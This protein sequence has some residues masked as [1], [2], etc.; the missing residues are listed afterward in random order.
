MTH[1]IGRL[2]SLHIVASLLAVCTI[3][4]CGED[5]PAAPANSPP[6]SPA[7]S[8]TANPAPAAAA[9]SES[10]FAGKWKGAKVQDGSGKNLTGG[11]FSD[12]LAIKLEIRPD[13]T[14]GESNPA[15]GHI[16]GTWA[17]SGDSITLTNKTAPTAKPIKLT[18]E[19]PNLVDRANPDMVLTY[20]KTGPVS[21]DT[22]PK[23]K[24]TAADLQ[25]EL[26]KSYDAAKN[27]YDELRIELTGIVTKIQQSETGNVIFVAGPPAAGE[28]AASLYLGITCLTDDQQPWAMLGQMQPV[29]VTGIA[30][31]ENGSMALGEAKFALDGPSIMV[32]ISADALAAEFAKDK[33]A[34]KDKYSISGVGKPLVVTGTV[35][36][37]HTEKGDPF[38]LVLGKG[39]DKVICDYI[40]SGP[41]AAKEL[42]PVKV[43]DTVKLAGQIDS[44]SKASSPELNGC[45]LITK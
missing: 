37:K 7:A 1:I 4:G 34:T 22:T 23:F 19:S 35:L 36:E 20:E 32:N 29:K 16:D 27:K 39:N 6:S 24:L 9:A 2:T 5:K 26:A 38:S 44:Y 41:D 13:H 17:L 45:I 25:K 11:I 30:T 18:F 40:G 33:S 21:S 12:M 28:S 3:A 10:D 31:F 43:G 8:N 15:M 42:D 14:W